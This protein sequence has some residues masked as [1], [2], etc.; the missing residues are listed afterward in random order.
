M[1]KNFTVRHGALDRV[2]AFL[3]VAQHRKFSKAAAELG[4]TP[5]AISQVIPPVTPSSATP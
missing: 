4:A 3:A 1:K 5:S 2:E